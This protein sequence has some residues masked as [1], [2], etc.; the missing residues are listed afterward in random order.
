MLLT[1]NLFSL[2]SL[3]FFGFARNQENG[4]ILQL[5][6]HDKLQPDGERMS[7]E[8]EKLLPLSG[9]DKQDNEAALLDAFTLSSTL[10]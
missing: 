9:L 10:F 6:L 8:K 4:L 7:S 1:G 2:H 5:G 3:E